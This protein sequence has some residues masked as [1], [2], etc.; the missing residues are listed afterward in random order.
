MP[1]VRVKLYFVSGL[2]ALLVGGPGC[3]QS[4]TA[5][6]TPQTATQSAG[7]A[8]APHMALGRVYDPQESFSIVLPPGWRNTGQTTHHFMTFLGPVEGP[9]TV[10]FNVLGD[11][12]D[13]TPVESARPKV[14][15]WMTVLLGNYQM[16]EEGFTQVAGEKVYFVSGTFVWDGQ[17]VRNLQYF[18][19]GA[20]KR[21][22]VLTFAAPIGT[23]AKHRPVFEET[24]Q[25][26]IIR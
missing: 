17:K 4:Y 3:P 16:V 11:K 13:G 22:Y 18:I 20:N 26:V 6:V 19:R 1:L 15:G 24:A 8:A 14:L 10:N 9:F 2:L 7:E 25:T 23:F 5:H 12:D 21:A